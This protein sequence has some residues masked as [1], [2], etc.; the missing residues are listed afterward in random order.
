MRRR[1]NELVT[2]Q[3]KR[4][5][6]YI[7]GFSIIDLEIEQLFQIILKN[8]AYVSG[9]TKPRTHSTTILK[10]VTAE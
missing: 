1:W 3:G 10:G 9:S 6:Q 7:P 8:T 5:K 4:F 2:F